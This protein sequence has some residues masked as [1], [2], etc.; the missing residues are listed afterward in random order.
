MR[1]PVAPC[2]D[3]IVRRTALIVDDHARW[4]AL[5]RGVLQ[6]AGF[7]VVVRRRWMVVSTG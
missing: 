4:R 3:G 1:D 2:D 5:S 7:D 6:A